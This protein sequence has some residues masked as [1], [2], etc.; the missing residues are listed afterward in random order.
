[1]TRYTNKTVKLKAYKFTE[2]QPNTRGSIAPKLTFRPLV[3]HTETI[4]VPLELVDSYKIAGI[5][6]KTPPTKGSSFPKNTHKKMDIPAA[7]PRK[8][9][10][11]NGTLDL[12]FGVCLIFQEPI[13]PHAK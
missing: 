8:I 7:N 5:I 11:H 9:L 6:D 4:A 3:S 10:D 12:D 13:M 1:M 2:L